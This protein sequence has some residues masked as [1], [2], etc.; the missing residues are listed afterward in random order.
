MNC[1][2]PNVNCK[3]KIYAGGDTTETM[4]KICE[5]DRELNHEIFGCE[6]CLHNM[7]LEQK[8]HAAED[9]GVDK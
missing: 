2:C 9:K 6:K 5:Y 3:D 8:R 4:N 7:K 1:T